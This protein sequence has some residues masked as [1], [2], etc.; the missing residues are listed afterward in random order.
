MGREAFVA[1][2]SSWVQAPVEDVWAVLAD[3][4]SYALWV[5]GTVKIRE[6]DPDW[7]AV[8]ARLHHQVG[9][10]PLLLAD[11]TEVLACEPAHRL[12][13]RARGWPAGEAR[14]ELVL[15]ADGDQTQVVMTEE[16][17]SGP[18]AWLH[19]PV[20][21]AVLVRRVAESLDRLRRPVEGRRRDGGAG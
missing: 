13:L 18:G 20:L 11:S 10:W 8:G 16:P 6:V 5:V 7:P 19:N 1:R 12:V 21:E 3:G 17:T 2:V 9:A 15:G 4:W 14:V